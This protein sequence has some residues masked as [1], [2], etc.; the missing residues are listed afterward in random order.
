MG[1]LKY[2]IL[3]LLTRKSMTGYD[4]AKEFETTLF[5]FWSAKHSQIYTE[6]NLLKESG[7]VDYKIEISGNVLEKK[8]YSITPA[9]RAEFKNW[10]NASSQKAYP[11]KDEFRLQLFFSDCISFEHRLNLLKNQLTYYKKRLAHLQENLKKF[12]ALPPAKEDELSDY[13]VL[14]GAIIREE[15]NCR[16]M[17]ECIRLCEE[18]RPS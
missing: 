3:G 8:L 18:R 11:P 16:W 9:G 2:A 5:E 14:L 13:M 4:M 1:T 15:G 17:E 10:E 7:L 12:D 6:L